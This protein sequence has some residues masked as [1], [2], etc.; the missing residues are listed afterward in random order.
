MECV[1]HAQPVNT[2]SFKAQLNVQFVQR[3]HNALEK[4]KFGSTLAIGETQ[5]THP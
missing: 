4:T 5:Q 2:Q 1:M 3:T